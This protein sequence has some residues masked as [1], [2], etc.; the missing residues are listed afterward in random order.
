MV[1]LIIGRRKR[2][3]SREHVTMP[4]TETKLKAGEP[5]NHPDLNR[6]EIV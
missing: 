1:S 2:E 6:I 4:A 3:G 5:S